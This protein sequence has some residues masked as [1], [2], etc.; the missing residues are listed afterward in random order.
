MEVL[1]LPEATLEVEEFAEGVEGP[2]DVG[3]AEPAGEVGEGE[4][5]GGGEGGEV[6]AGTGEGLEK[7]KV[8][9]GERGRSVDGRTG[10]HERHLFGI[11]G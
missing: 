3:E 11:V 8:V 6:R 2:A 1:L 5:A 10:E 4:A 9:R 7:G